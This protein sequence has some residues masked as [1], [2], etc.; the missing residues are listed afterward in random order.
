MI[1]TSVFAPITKST[2]NDDGTLYVYGKATGSDVDLDQQRCDPNWLKRAMP[3]WFQNSYG[4]GGNIR[5]QHDSKRAIG[6][7]TEHEVKEDGHYIRA[8]IVDP[9]AVAKTKAGIFSGFSIGI[10]RP[11]IEKSN[12]EEW[13]RSGDICEVSLVDR[14]CLPTATL[15]VCKAAKPG[16]TTKATDFD[17]KRMLVRVEELVEEEPEVQKVTDVDHLDA[18]APGQKCSDCGAD[19]HLKCADVPDMQV[20]LAD[21]L[22]PEQKEKLTSK[23]NVQVNLDEGNFADQIKSIVDERINASRTFTEI[24]KSAAE[25]LAEGRRELLREAY[26]APDFDRDAA[27]KLVATLTKAGNLPPEYASEQEDIS[28]AQDAIRIISQLIQSEAAEM[29]DNPAEDCDIQLLLSAVSALRCFIGREQEQ[30]MGADVVDAPMVSLAAEAD[31]TKD[32]KEPYG[33]VTYADPG[34]Q[35]DGKKRYPLDTKEH[36]KAA[37]SYINQADNA[38]KYSADQLKT[39]KS[40]IKSACKKFGVEVDADATKGVAMDDTTPVDEVQ[41]TID[42]TVEDAPVDLEKSEDVSED[43]EK[44]D[45]PS[46]DAEVEVEKT[47]D[48]ETTKAAVE[49]DGESLVKA[50][51]AALSKADSPLRKSFETIVNAANESTVKSVSALAERLEAVERM[52]TPGGPAQRRTEVERNQARRNDLIAEVVRFKSLAANSDD[53]M[54]RKGYAQKASQLEAEIR[55]L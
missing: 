49:D 21:R 40:R 1:T 46:E 48:P 24:G 33:D 38:D 18:P 5:E 31:A 50:L 52:A 32:S 25:G 55:S 4:Y 6:T 23:L 19:G 47:V 36:A 29:V 54:L 51:E 7:A 8:H 12:G 14:P 45:S 41:K 9:V 11:R 3:D 34:Y 10:S 17:S 35:K 28:G 44:T 37:W 2:E 27:V 15:T 43:V 16:M 26:T 39:M 53:Q 13:I 22:S 20:T 30:A 42:D